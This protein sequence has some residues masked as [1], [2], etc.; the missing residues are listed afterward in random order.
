MFD[1]VIRGGTVVDGSGRPAV[2]ADVAIKD[3]V[4]AEVGRVGPGRRELD[5]SGALVTPGWVDVHTHYDGQVTWDPLLTPSSWHGV[6]T[7]VMGNCGVGFAPA[8][9]DKH[10]WLIGLMEGVEDIPGAALAEGINWAWETFPQYM[11]AIE[12]NARAIDFGVQLPHGAIRAYVMGERGAQN[13]EATAEDVAAM[14]QVV[15]E[16]LL[17]GA[18]GF[19]TS[20]T[21]MHRSIDGI[22]VPGT[23]A[24]RLE[25]FGIGEALKKTGRG[26][27]QLAAQHEDVPDE[28]EWMDEL[29]RYTGRPVSFNL[30]QIDPDPQLWRRGLERL[31]RADR[32]VVAQVAG[33]GIGI[34]MCWE[35]TAHPFLNRAAYLPFHELSPAERRA[36]LE[37]PEVRQAIIESPMM[38]LDELGNFVTRSWHKMFVAEPGQTMSY[39]PGA[40]HSVAAIAARTGRSCEEIAYDALME[41]DGRGTLYF[42]LFNYAEGSLAPQ[43]ELLSHPRTRLGLSDGGAHCGAICD[44]GMATFM[45]THWT[46]DRA[47]GPR[48]GLERVVAM[49]THET[50]QLFGL[51][52]RGL[53]KP[54]Y[55]ADV[56]L[57]DYANLRLENPKMA[58]DLPLGG[59]RLVQRAHGYVATVVSGEV[60]MEHGES[61]GALPGRLLRGARS[62]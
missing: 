3:G 31:E 34:I 4:I 48:L 22:P 42:P 29:A 35:G 13:E 23:F 16:G 41:L 30:S 6:T 9:P 24:D 49:Q 17:A 57:I 44:G 59:R 28:L 38:E 10:D 8:K 61:T 1:L 43:Y 14:A 33:R 47:R 20:R 52:D 58:Y 7:V 54:G 36:Q 26:V 18:L 62:L 60:I 45:L 21:L 32:R 40:E 11:D 39:E 46:R 51:G 25:L 27:F 50:A 19:S 2:L 37:R 12:A 15:E 5:A 53:L 55:K 56:N